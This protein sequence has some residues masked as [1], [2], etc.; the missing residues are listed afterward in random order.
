MDAILQQLLAFPPHPPPATPPSDAEYDKQIN[1]Q[2]QHLNHIPASK[3]IAPVP[4]GGDL[5]DVSAF[6][7][8]L[9]LT[10]SPFCRPFP[11]KSSQ[12][13]LCTLQ[14]SHNS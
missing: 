14:V 5:L 7:Q 1:I 3:L 6:P 9:S 8:C 10:C 2:I 11:L 13:Q 12:L 4:G